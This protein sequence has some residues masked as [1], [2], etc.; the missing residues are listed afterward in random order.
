MLQ[1]SF[2]GGFWMTRS[3]RVVNKPL[4][5]PS[6]VL[7]SIKFPKLD[8]IPESTKA[9]SWKQLFTLSSLSSSSRALLHAINHASLHQHCISWFLSFEPCCLVWE[10]LQVMAQ[11]RTYLFWSWP[12]APCLFEIMFIV[13][14]RIF[15]AMT[16]SRRRAAVMRWSHIFSSSFRSISVWAHNVC[17]IDERHIYTFSVSRLLN[18][19]HI[20][21]P[22][23]ISDHFLPQTLHASVHHRPASDSG[24]TQPRWQHVQ[25]DPSWHGTI[26]DLHWSVLWKPVRRAFG[27]NFAIPVSTATSPIPRRMYCA[28][29]SLNLVIRKEW[30]YIFLN[31]SAKDCIWTSEGLS[32]IAILTFSLG[33]QFLAVRSQ[34]GLGQEGCKIYHDLSKE[35]ANWA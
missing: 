27:E 33:K 32:L 14:S 9:E 20:C 19:I 22:E 5:P 3:V 35:R 21:L 8:N 15:A 11:P 31:P 24:W 25:C 13:F 28:W 29:T 30:I 12:H 4:A 6:I 16:L 23:Q 18:Y 17:Y 1:S 2:Q 34:Q 26:G 7:P 10:A